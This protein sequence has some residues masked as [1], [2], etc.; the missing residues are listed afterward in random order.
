MSHHSYSQSVSVQSAESPTARSR[1]PREMIDARRVFASGTSYTTTGDES[2]GGE[3][4]LSSRQPGERDREGSSSDSITPSSECLRMH[5]RMHS[6]VRGT[7]AV[8]PGQYFS[9]SS[10]RLAVLRLS[11]VSITVESV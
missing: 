8:V 10:R 2:D 9:C 1:V 3:S 4:S 6:C 5:A 11:S 7:Q